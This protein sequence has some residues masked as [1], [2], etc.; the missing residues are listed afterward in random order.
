MT[1]AAS[2]ITA[3]PIGARRPGSVGLPAGLSVQVTGADGRPVPTGTVG[4]VAIAGE[5]VVE[6]YW[7]TANGAVPARPAVDG[8]GW[9]ATGDLG[10]FDD[11]GYLYLDGRADDVINRSGEKIHP[12]EI[13]ELLLREPGVMAAS[14][15]GRPHPVYGE[16]PVAFV[17]PAGELDDAWD[18]PA[19]L[20][21]RCE[22][23]LTRHKRPAEIILVGQPA[24]RD[25]PARF[26]AADLRR[27][28]QERGRHM[29][30]HLSRFPVL[31]TLHERNHHGSRP[32]QPALPH[33]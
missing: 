28:P 6:E 24:G 16:E 14:V 30:A 20:E 13:E 26:A 10:H 25:R 12:R 1:E 21:A 22:Q 19:R 2:Q 4:M 7:S 33:D 32:T 8:H 29:T 18:L 9:L 5:S 23:F 11:E 17:V 31:F 15:V 27:L 3:N